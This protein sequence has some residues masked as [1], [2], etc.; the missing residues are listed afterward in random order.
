MLLP[1]CDICGIPLKEELWALQL[2][3]IKK[4]EQPDY[5]ACQSVNEIVQKMEQAYSNRNRTS[6][7][8]EL[9]P[10]CKKILDH[11]FKLRK[12]EVEKIKQELDSSMLIT[13][14]EEEEKNDGEEI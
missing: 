2:T 8:K 5:S 7:F 14:I 3:E 4:D 10:E 9:C 6:L 13:E 1:I 12:N 11:F